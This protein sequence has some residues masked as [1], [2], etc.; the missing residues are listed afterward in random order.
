MKN[1]SLAPPVALTVAGSDSSAG[2]G[3]QADLKTFAAH[4]VYGLAAATCIVAEIPGAVTA[5]QP[6][7]PAIVGEQIRLSLRAFPVAAVKTGMLYS[8]AII[9]AVADLLVPA[10][11]PLVVDPV[12]VAASGD[13]LLQ[14]AAV[15]EYRAR[16]FPAATLITPNLD[17]AA[18]LLGR[19]LTSVPELRDAAAALAAMFGTAVL[20]KGGHLAGDTATDLL[21]ADGR[22]HEFGAPFIRDVA[23]RDTHGTGCTYSAAIA[24]NLARGLPLAAAVGAAKEY[25]TGA[26]RARF[27]W[28]A[29]DRA[30]PPT[31]ALDHFHGQ[32]SPS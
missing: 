6:A 10:R 14:P 4:G 21:F 24:A 23:A 19:P 32:S 5:I 28:P 27:L 9:A 13:P 25:I 22:P 15:A 12:M 11:L 31:A 2:A 18:A 29:P 20:V 16:L 7:E 8:R 30:L 26:I 3:L 1:M 17:E